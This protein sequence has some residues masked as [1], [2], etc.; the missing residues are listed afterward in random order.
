MADR[1]LERWFLRFRDRGD[2]P[3]LGRVFDDVSGELL[4]IAA[5]VA[6]GPAEA[7][8]L[9]QEVFLAAIER[10]NRYEAG[11]PLLPW[12]IGLLS[13][14]A[15]RTRSRVADRQGRIER[16]RDRQGARGPESVSSD[17][18]PDASASQGELADW[19]HDAVDRVA[20]PYRSVLARH[21]FDLEGAREIA[22]DLG[23]SP[24][25]VRVQLHRG[26]EIL[27][28]RLPPGFAVG[29]SA[30]PGN[31]RGLAA[32]RDRVLERGANSMPTVGV[33]TA[34]ALPTTLLGSA[35]AMKNWIVPI[36]LF[37]VVLWLRP[38]PWARGPDPQEA[39]PLGIEVTRG[40]ALADQG[41]KASGVDQG[42]SR[43]EAH[44]D[45]AVEPIAP[46]VDEDSQ[47]ASILGRV[48]WHDLTPAAGV[49][50]FLEPDVDRVPQRIRVATRSD[51]EGH[52]RFDGVRPG[53][54]H[55]FADRG[56]EL[57][58]EV[59][60]EDLD[61]QFIIPEGVEVVGEVVDTG[62]HPVAG[63]AIWLSFPDRPRDGSRVGTADARGRFTLPSV[64]P[65]CAVGA[66]AEGY[67]PSYTQLLNH[68]AE[69]VGVQRE[70]RL[71]LDEPGGRV[72]VRV[73]DATGA[74][75]EG[76]TVRAG[77]IYLRVR[78][79]DNGI[80][81]HS[82]AAPE[83]STDAEGFVRLG[84]VPVGEAPISVHAEGYAVANEQLQVRH[85]GTSTLEVVLGRGGT[86]TGRVVDS[87][88][89]GI[90][91]T[92]VI[93]R[94][95]SHFK[96]PQDVSDSSGRYTLPFVPSGDIDLAAQ[97]DRGFFEEHLWVEEG[98]TVEFEISLIEGLV[99]EGRALDAD[100]EPL[101]GWYAFGLPVDYFNGP[102]WRETD[103]EGRFRFTNCERAPHRLELRPSPFSNE[104]THAALDGVW[105]GRGA[106]EL[107]IDPLHAPSAHV[108]G[109]IQ[110]PEGHPEGSIRVTLVPTSHEGRLDR[111]TEDAAHSFAF[112][113][114]P[115]DHYSLEARL[116]GRRA[117]AIA[118]FEL[119]L[120][121][122]LD[123]GLLQIEEPGSLSIDLVADAPIDPSTIDF[124]LFDRNRHAWSVEFDPKTSRASADNLL[125]GPYFLVVRSPG[126]AA[127]SL[128]IEV[129]AG[130]DSR[131]ELALAPGVPMTLWVDLRNPDPRASR[132]QLHVYGPFPRESDASADSGALQLWTYVAL[133][134]GR[135]HVEIQETLPPGAYLAE[136]RSLVTD[137]V[138]TRGT[139]SAE[140]TPG[141]AAPP[142]PLIVE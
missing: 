112:G 105:P 86:I 22:R 37:A 97:H 130:R 51:A 57:W 90:P 5:H 42:S 137:E 139:F 28:R 59:E 58:P 20:E 118:H 38:D 29:L 76:A 24:G 72:E 65:R 126:L 68:P 74:P 10:R 60:D 79:H 128:W 132:T 124:D 17:P 61:L 106:V 64:R 34:T 36:A 15:R 131:S 92:A 140:G 119:A 75:I 80:V 71:V 19:L 87:G 101:E 56:G 48:L 127:S 47:D 136:L 54:A 9:V 14:E 133:F 113:P 129:E 100:G 96:R 40:D 95:P 1:R 103:A 32:V 69:E 142:F 141:E 8:D 46:E 77:P 123:L 125:P 122:E 50:V 53:T 3:A 49:G 18:T 135:E 39:A 134:E 2:L 81:E 13:I 27:R 99:L 4:G 21:L 109:E 121:D 102:N 98:E 70:V 83:G 6:P 115:P 55:V 104:V 67:G 62:G 52:F 82:G 111:T 78:S 138:L 41:P 84:S 31:T 30:L 23:R 16:E 11:R 110:L 25:T 89:D 33:A 66:L 73:V 117:Q 7:E 35:L 107:R 93:A 12:L 114:V 108:R 116:E 43:S 91:G 26:L 45:V 94:G 88:G 85:R 63:A 120:G 44:L